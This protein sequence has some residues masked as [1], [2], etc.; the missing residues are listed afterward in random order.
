V[1]REQKIR[2]PALGVE[3]EHLPGMAF[4]LL[5]GGRPPGA[6][7]PV[8]AGRA[9]A[10]GTHPQPHGAGERQ[11]LSGVQKIVFQQAVT[12]DPDAAMLDFEQGDVAS[13]KVKHL[14]GLQRRQGLALPLQGER[15]RRLGLQCGRRRGGGVQ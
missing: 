11:A 5:G 3:A 8:Q 15:N 12:G 14:D 4:E 2:G 1:N 10:F 6:A 13:A 7:S 9:L